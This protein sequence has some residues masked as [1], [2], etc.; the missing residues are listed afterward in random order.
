MFSARLKPCPDGD[1]AKD[2]TPGQEGKVPTC[3]HR[4]VACP[5]VSIEAEPKPPPLKTKGGA[6]G[7]M[8]IRGRG[9]ESL[10]PEGLSYRFETEGLSDTRGVGLLGWDVGQVGTELD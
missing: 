6:P 3:D 9:R 2:D 5:A 8:R 10:R 7:S 1:E 4:R